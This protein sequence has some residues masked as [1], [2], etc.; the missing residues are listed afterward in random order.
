MPS[1]GGEGTRC[2]HWTDE[3]EMLFFC[4]KQQGCTRRGGHWPSACFVG[5]VLR[6]SDARPYGSS[7]A[8]APVGGDP[9]IDPPSSSVSL[10]LPASLQG[11][12]FVRQNPLV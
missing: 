9:R 11:E 5:C 1:P 10:R 3:V 8:L 6:T 7:T 12:A 2:A 4:R